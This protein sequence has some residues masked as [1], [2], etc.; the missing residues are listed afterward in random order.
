M[1]GLWPFVFAFCPAFAFRYT[2]CLGSRQKLPGRCED[3]FRR[4]APCQHARQL[5]NSALFIQSTNLGLGAA[6]A[7]A[8]VNDEVRVGLGG[9]LREVRNAQDLE[10]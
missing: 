7:D 5:R 1:F 2:C 10:S 8:L 6:T 9:D 3:G 4:G